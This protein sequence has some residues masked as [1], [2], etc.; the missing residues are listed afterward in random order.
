MVQANIL[1]ACADTFSLE[2]NV[3]NIA[4]A[5][6]TSLN[7]LAT[8]IREQL[9]SYGIDTQASRL[10]Y[11]DF[12]SGDVKHSLA[13]IDFARRALGYDPIYSLSEGLKISLPWYISSA[14]L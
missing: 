6:Q 9:K 5:E 4:F 1:A 14:N 2:Q 10:I 8:I 12:R 11:Q 13:S 7:E 3:F